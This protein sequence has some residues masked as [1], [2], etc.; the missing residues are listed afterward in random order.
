MKQFDLTWHGL[1]GGEGD[2]SNSRIELAFDNANQKDLY[3]M[4]GT[5]TLL[6]IE[7]RIHRILDPYSFMYEGNSCDRCGCD[8]HI[9][10][11]KYYICED[12]EIEMEYETSKEKLLGINE[13]EVLYNEILR[14]S[15]T[16]NLRIS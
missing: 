10:N 8:I 13:R 16:T 14:R 12:C 3:S 1:F 9:L 5:Y 11:S 15:N 4:L 6:G 2:G 7:D